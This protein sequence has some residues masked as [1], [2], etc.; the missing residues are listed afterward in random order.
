MPYISP[1]YLSIWNTF[2]PFCFV[3][4]TRRQP[5]AASQTVLHFQANSCKTSLSIYGA[6]IKVKAS[7][8]EHEICEIRWDRFAVFLGDCSVQISAFSSTFTVLPFLLLMSA[9]SSL[10]WDI[11]KLSIS[12][13]C[14]FQR[15]NI[16]IIR[17]IFWTVSAMSFWLVWTWARITLSIGYSLFFFRV[18]EPFLNH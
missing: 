9:V 8:V 3:I 15:G 6:A 12:L 10:F 2:S 16:L 13:S 7:W 17:T 18:S 5:S 4:T 11:H 14:P 1:D